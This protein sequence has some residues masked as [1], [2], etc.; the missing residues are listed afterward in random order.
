MTWQTGFSPSQRRTE[1]TARAAADLKRA[2]ADLLV[3]QTVIRMLQKG[4]VSEFLAVHLLGDR[5]AEY[6]PEEGMSK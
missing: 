3:E 2:E 4:T 6:L 1:A 5:I